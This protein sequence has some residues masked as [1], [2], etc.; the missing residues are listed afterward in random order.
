MTDNKK[1]DSQEI[2]RIGFFKKV[3]YSMTK[4]EKYPEMAAEGMPRAFIYLSQ[5]MLI[6]SVIVSLAFLYKMHTAVISGAEYIKN[7]LPNITYIDGKLNVESND[8]I[9]IN[10]ENLVIDKII[11]DTNTEDNS[12][13]EEYL[14]SIP[15][16]NSGILVLKD[17]VMFKSYNMA[18]VE[19]YKYEEILSNISNYNFNN[20]TKQNIVD[21]LT[22]NMMISVYCMLFVLMIIYIFIMYLMSVLIDSLLIA[23]LGRI[24]VVF[25]KLRLKFSAIYNMSIYAL[26]ISILLNSIYIAINT[27]TGFK[28]EYFQ[29]M[30]TSIAYVCLVASIFMIK[31]DFMKRQAEVMKIIE[32]QQKVKQEIKEQED[33][34]EKNENK[35]Q[36]DEEKSSDEKEN[37]KD[38]GEPSG[39]EA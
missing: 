31:L 36:K 39:S 15:M 7:E 24:T 2:K 29:I 25:T 32:E 28:L 30:Y 27:V 38:D 9:I 11:I 13:V 18:G 4:F 20:F 16:D 35:K 33:E 6:F 10:T 12:K 5:I 3:W 1:E 23:V 22:G 17:K 14:N 21:Y 37:T 19:S 34:E 26:T 8:A